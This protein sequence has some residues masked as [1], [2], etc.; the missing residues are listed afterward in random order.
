MAVET[1]NMRYYRTFY[2]IYTNDWTE[3]FGSGV[4]SDNHYI[5][6]GDYISDGCDTTE[7]STCSSGV[8][9][10]FLYPHHIDKTYFIEGVIQGHIT[11]AA[12]LATSTVTDYRVTVCKV[13]TDGTETEL[14][15]TGVVAVNDTL[16]WDSTYSVGQERVYPFWIDAWGYK[17]LTE[18]E[19]I[20][21]KIEVTADDNAVL[22]HSNDATWED[23]KLEIPFIR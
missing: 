8:T 1:D 18:D 7:S 3:D 5:L 20:Y 15:S 17:T 6:V 16:T 23:L 4:F 9:L 11:I 19:R 10:Y 13:H 12:S 22:W 21:I 2:G 14:F